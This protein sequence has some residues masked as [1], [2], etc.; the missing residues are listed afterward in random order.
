MIFS[1]IDFRANF[2]MNEEA[3]SAKPRLTKSREELQHECWLKGATP[4]VA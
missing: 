4:S 3:R 1:I 2:R